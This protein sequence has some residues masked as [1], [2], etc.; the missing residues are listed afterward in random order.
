[1]FF[2]KGLTSSSTSSNSEPSEVVIQ[3][4]AT[5]TGVSPH[6]VFPALHVAKRSVMFKCSERK[7]WQYNLSE[8]MFAGLVSF[9]CN[10]FMDSSA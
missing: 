5:P 2:L 6:D 1:M 3:C 7:K 8:F 4:Y 9:T 10:L